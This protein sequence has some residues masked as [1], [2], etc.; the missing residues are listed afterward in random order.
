MRQETPSEH[1]IDKK[2]AALLKKATLT[3]ESVAVYE[4]GYK[5]W[6]AE[7]GKLYTKLMA[8]LPKAQK[9]TLA[10]SQSAW[11]AYREK[12]LRFAADFHSS[13]PGTIWNVTRASFRLDF[14]KARAL[15]LEEFLDN[16]DQT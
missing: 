14:V 10:A 9:A 16:L 2:I 15:E 4:Q 12:D 13:L 6:D 3:H 11:L 1:P 7:L 8:R 5:L